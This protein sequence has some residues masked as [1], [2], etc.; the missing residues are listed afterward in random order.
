[1][2]G[3]RS[4]KFSKGI[5]AVVLFITLLLYSMRRSCQRYDEKACLQDRLST[6]G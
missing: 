3:S 2:S 5:A 1:V 6:L 4:I